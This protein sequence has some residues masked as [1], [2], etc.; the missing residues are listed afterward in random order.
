MVRQ[1]EC[2]CVG[3]EL[4][5]S[6]GGEGCGLSGSAGGEGCD[7]SDSAGGEAGGLHLAAVLM[8][9]ALLPSGE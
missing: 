8:L 5:G 2:W 3:C 9:P 6:A 7:L 4:S 1:I